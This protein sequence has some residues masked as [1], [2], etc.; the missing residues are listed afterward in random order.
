V[1]KVKFTFV[2]CVRLGLIM[3][4]IV[5]LFGGLPFHQLT[6]TKEIVMDIYT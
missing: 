3:E 1:I 4:Q 2:K 6:I 5:S